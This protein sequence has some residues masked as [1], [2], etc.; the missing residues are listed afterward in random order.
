MIQED[1]PFYFENIFE[2]LSPGTWYLNRNDGT[3]YYCPKDDE[4][5][6]ELEVIYP[7]LTTLVELT[8]QQNISFENITFSHSHWYYPENFKAPYWPSFEIDG[9]AQVDFGVPA[10]I[11]IERSTN[12][13]FKNCSITNIGNYAIEFGEGCVENKVLDCLMNELG[14]GGIKLSQQSRETTIQNCMIQN[15]GQ[16][17]HSATG[18]L[19]RESHHNRII[20]NEIKNFYYTGISVGWIWGY[21]DSQ[22]HHNLIESNRIHHLGK[23]ENS[24]GPILNELGGIYVLGKQPGTVIKNN[25]IHDITGRPSEG[26]DY[27]P[28]GLGFYLDEGSSH[29]IIE[30]N[31]LYNIDIV[32]SQHYGK[33]N[34][35]RNNNFALARVAFLSRSK[36]E[37]HIS[38]TIEGNI[39]Y[40]RNVPFFIGLWSDGNFNINHN[41]Y[42]GVFCDELRFNKI[43]FEDWQKHG[44]DVH[45]YIVN[46]V[47]HSIY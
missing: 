45:S 32:L 12:C 13:S 20:D 40:G 6:H 14:A 1:C 10:A 9:F 23:L 2:Q 15:G 25:I 46:L 18:I 19:I 8:G 16:I 22:T 36:E 33:E 21:A 11:N 5:I 44:N 27:A 24:D 7:Y 35:I 29:L 38:F 26:L 34:I 47:K 17:F 41:I 42:C 39:F 28:S 37:Q 3:F 4:N 43:N 30:D 31:L